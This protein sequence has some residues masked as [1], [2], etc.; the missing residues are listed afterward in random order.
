MRVASSNVRLIDALLAGGTGALARWDHTQALRLDPERR[1][2]L[3][4]EVFERDRGGQFD[5]LFLAVMPGYGLGAM[6]NILGFQTRKKRFI[7]LLAGD[8]HALGVIQRDLLAFA[9]Q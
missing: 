8:R 1:V 6:V 7:D 2:E 5:D 9:E 4:A 3:A